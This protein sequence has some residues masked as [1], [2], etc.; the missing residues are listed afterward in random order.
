VKSLFTVLQILGFIDE[1]RI[2]IILGSTSS[3]FGHFVVVAAGTAQVYSALRFTKTSGCESQEWRHGL[4]RRPSRRMSF[5]FW[6]APTRRPIE[7]FEK[8]STRFSRNPPGGTHRSEKRQCGGTRRNSAPG[9]SLCML[10][11]RLSRALLSP[12]VFKY[13]NR[14]YPRYTSE[15]AVYASRRI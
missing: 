5:I 1:I 7:N 4:S 11:I 12:Y 3:L 15:P 9:E 14:N 13:L 6:S 2:L 10:P 8:K